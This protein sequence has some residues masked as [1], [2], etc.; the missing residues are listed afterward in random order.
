VVYFSLAHA[1][2]TVLLNGVIQPVEKLGSDAEV[3][4]TGGLDPVWK[5]FSFHAFGLGRNNHIVM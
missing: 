3:L 2:K 1:V 4:L 5:I